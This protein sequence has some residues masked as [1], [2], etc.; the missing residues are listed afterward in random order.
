MTEE[1][2]VFDGDYRKLPDAQER[3]GDV[4]R[5]ANDVGPQYPIAPGHVA[6]VLISQDEY[7]RLRGGKLTGADVIAAFQSCP[8]PHALVEPERIPL[9]FRN[10]TD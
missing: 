7:N 6:G 9:P 10:S 5:R 2:R 8:L 3:V 1:P 4:V